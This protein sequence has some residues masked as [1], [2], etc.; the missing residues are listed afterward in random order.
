MG[1]W[2]GSLTDLSKMIKK[3]SEKSSYS[4]ME[5]GL[6]SVGQRLSYYKI[7]GNLG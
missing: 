3:I 7:Y 2:G 4:L 5:F 1:V 6:Y